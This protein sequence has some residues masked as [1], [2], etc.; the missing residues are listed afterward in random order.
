MLNVHQDIEAVMRHQKTAAS[1]PRAIRVVPGPE[2]KSG[3]SIVAGFMPASVLI[4]NRFEVPYFDP[5]TKKGYQRPP[6]DARVNQ[7]VNDLR[8]E[9]VDLPTAVLL[10]IRNRNAKDAVQN[11]TLDALFASTALTKFF[12]VDGQHRVLALEKLMAENADEWGGFVLPFVCMLGATEDEEMEQFYIVNSTAKSVRTDL[13]LALLRKR[14]EGDEEVYIALQERGRSW[15]VDGQTLVERLAVE[16][17]IWRQRIRLPAMEKEQTTIPSASMVASLKP[18]LTSPYFG[19][20][21]LDQQLQVLDA[22]WQGMREALRPVFDAPGEYALQKGVGVI[23]MHTILPHVLELVRSNGWSVLEADSYS[24]ILSE[25]LAKLQGDDGEGN[26]ISGV[27]FWAAAPVGA[28]GSYSSSA[29]RR[30]L[31]AKI[32][33]LL[34][35]VEAE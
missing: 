4:P 10:N 26:P 6:N 15:Q 25:P 16:S 22:F 28:A 13:A 3:V 1:A 7:L 2:L 24:R 11:G 29:G 21:K 17:P 9:R 27:Q 34:P 31:A 8:K 18:L 14:A 20:L 30:V 19:S 5:R 32:R 12:I 23:V 35:A 33:Q